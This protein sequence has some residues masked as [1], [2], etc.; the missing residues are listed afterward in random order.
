M[1]AEAAAR[2]TIHR[3]GKGH[4]IFTERGNER[5]CLT[6]EKKGQNKEEAWATR[7]EH[8]LSRIT[9]RSALM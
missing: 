1:E 8:T 6:S 9:W 7:P 2:V 5:L 3:N 4:G